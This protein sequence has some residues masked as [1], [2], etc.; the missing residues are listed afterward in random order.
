LSYPE[1]TR[2]QF[3]GHTSAVFSHPSR[4]GDRFSSASNHVQ[5]SGENPMFLAFLADNIAFL[6]YNSQEEVLFVAESINKITA[7]SG[8][9]V[10]RV[11]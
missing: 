5:K 4:S 3:G 8:D 11:R 9:H 6:P 7:H 1:V 10:L 2:K